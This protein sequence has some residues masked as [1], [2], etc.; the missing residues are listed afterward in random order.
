MQHARDGAAACFSA[1]DVEQGHRILSQSFRFSNI[2]PAR[3]DAFVDKKRSHERAA[4]DSDSRLQI[5]PPNRG[6][7]VIGRGK[8]SSICKNRPNFFTDF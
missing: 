7:R 6:N 5:L 3:W 4:P 8:S 1:C 2:F